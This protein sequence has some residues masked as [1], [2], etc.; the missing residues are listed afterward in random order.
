MPRKARK[1][2][3]SGIYHVV[4]RGINKRRTIR[5]GSYLLKLAP[6]SVILVRGNPMPRKARKKS[7]T[8]IYHV[9]LRGIN[10]QSI[11]EDKQDFRKFLETIKKSREK[12]EYKLY[13]YCLMSNHIH[14]LIKEGT[15]TQKGTVL[16][17]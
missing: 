2:S 11:F 10:K 6:I 15:Q 12:S 13:A 14:L 5:D 17:C 16:I 8:G 1:K 3:S 9:V 4:L 7:N